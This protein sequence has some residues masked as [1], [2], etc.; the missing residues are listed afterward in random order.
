MLNFHY[1][2]LK[3]EFY[4]ILAFTWTINK[5]SDTIHKCCNNQDHKKKYHAQEHK[6]YHGKPFYS[7]EENST[8]LCYILKRRSP[9]HKTLMHTRGCS[10]TLKLAPKRGAHF[11]PKMYLLKFPN[12]KCEC[13]SSM[14]K[15]PLFIQYWTQQKVCL[16]AQQGWPQ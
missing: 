14:G 11:S 6:K 5:C 16:L 7:R 12:D 13:I 9:N 8:I 15:S 10:T 1:A 2:W 4:F 3:H